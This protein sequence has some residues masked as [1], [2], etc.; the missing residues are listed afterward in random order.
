MAVLVVQ[1]AAPRIHE[2]A[3]LIHLVCIYNKLLQRMSVRQVG[4]ACGALLA[5][6][7]VEAEGAC[8]IRLAPAVDATHLRLV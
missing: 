8:W 6:L 2:H 3:R 4:A 1:A 7:E 5:P